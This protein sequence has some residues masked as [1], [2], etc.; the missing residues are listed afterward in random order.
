MHM[1]MAEPQHMAW[2][3]TAWA[4]LITRESRKIRAEPDLGRDPRI[5]HPATHPDATALTSAPRCAGFPRLN[6]LL[7]P[8]GGALLSLA[9]HN[10][11]QRRRLAAVG[12]SAQSR[13]ERVP[14]TLWGNT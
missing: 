5:H 9:H 4:D 11:A 13:V 2:H 7:R 3:G 14:R 10:H 8:S 1:H 12:A 6:R